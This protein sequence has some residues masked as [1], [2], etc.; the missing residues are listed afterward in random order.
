MNTDRIKIKVPKLDAARRQLNMAIKLWFNGEDPVAIHT[1]AFAAYEV[2]HVI[3]KKR[4]PYRQDLLF[5]SDLIKDEYRKDWNDFIK[6]PG[7]FFKHAK[8][9]ADETI[10]FDPML[11]E[12]FLLFAIAAVGS[13]REL[14]NDE[15]SVFTLWL[16]F[17]MP[18]I[19]TEEGRKLYIDRFSVDELEKIKSI[20][21]RDFF[22][23]AMSMRR[24]VRSERDVRNV[25]RFSPN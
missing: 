2:L 24:K 10:E 12:L 7:N 14:P 20:P 16:A 19:L 25:G 4:N 18:N 22:E 15:E 8:N 1:L 21:K 11:S 9:D 13:C 6:K 17:H 23:T 5:D 3:S